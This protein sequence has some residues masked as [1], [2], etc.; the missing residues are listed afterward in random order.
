MFFILLFYI[1]RIFFIYCCWSNFILHIGQISIWIF[2]LKYPKKFQFDCL[3]SLNI[4]SFLSHDCNVP[5]SNYNF[6]PFLYTEIF[7]TWSHTAVL[8]YF[9]I[10]LYLTSFQHFFGTPVLRRFLQNHRCLSVCQFG[11]FLMNGPLV[12]SDF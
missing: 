2:F 1:L 3:Y 10:V 7:R 6:R 12:F 5:P 8:I 9:W 11:I 4:Y